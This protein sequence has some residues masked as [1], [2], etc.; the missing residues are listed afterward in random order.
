[1]S[2]LNLQ[3]GQPEEYGSAEVAR[4]SDSQEVAEESE[5]ADMVQQGDSADAVDLSESA[6]MQEEGESAQVVM[7]SDL[8][9]MVEEEAETWPSVGTSKSS[10][11]GW[12]S[13]LSE[14]HVSFYQACNC[15][16]VCAL[17]FWL[18]LKSF[19]CQPNI[20]SMQFGSLPCM[21]CPLKSLCLQ[22]SNL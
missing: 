5:S 17:C 21:N 1:M 13:T 16:F 22:Q 19:A 8:A 10:S 15:V 11:K 7:E 4:E 20:V 2:R 9:N 3:V 6:D 18:S 12:G 14:S